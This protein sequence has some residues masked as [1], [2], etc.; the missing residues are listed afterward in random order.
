[1]GGP[2]APELAERWT[3]S[4]VD[5]AD[6]RSSDVTQTLGAPASVPE[7]AGGQELAV[8]VDGLVKGFG[9]LGA[10]AGVSFS[11]CRARYSPSWARTAPIA[12]R[13]F[14]RPV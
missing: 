4:A 8:D 9:E 1:M 11:V 10:V 5:D 3:R 14:N 6:S 7:A 13:G 2:G 12:V